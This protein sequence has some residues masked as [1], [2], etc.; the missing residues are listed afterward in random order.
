MLYALI[1]FGISGLAIHFADSL[2]AEWAPFISQAH[3]AMIVALAAAFIAASIASMQ[4]AW[5][6]ERA[7]QA[8][9]AYR[10][11]MYMSL[12]YSIACIVIEVAIG[13]LGAMML[14]LDVPVLALTALLVFFAIAPRIV[15]FILSGLDG[16]EHVEAKAADATEHGRTLDRIRAVNEATSQRIQAGVS[17]LEQERKARA[18]S[19]HGS[20]ALVGAAAALLGAGGDPA[21]AQVSYPVIDAQL[22]TTQ[23]ELSTTDYP[24]L[25]TIAPVAREL[26]TTQNELPPA[27]RDGMRLGPRHVD[28]YARMQRILEQTPSIS[29]RRLGR[30]ISVHHATV[31][32]WRAHYR[33]QQAL[34]YAQNGALLDNVA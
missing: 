16:I 10:H 29:N 3:T 32:A 34:A 11:I 6:A 31:K 9:P 7:R 17:N 14:G 1:V 21:S 25:S 20:I 8:G 12:A 15:A 4:A 5:H 28:A 23:N 18:G 30:A 27:A 2:P 22:S 19:V 33:A 24:E 26:S 13:K